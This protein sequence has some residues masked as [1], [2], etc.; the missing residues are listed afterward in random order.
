MWE[1]GSVAQLCSNSILIYGSDIF[2]N[3]FISSGI[4]LGEQEDEDPE[5]WTAKMLTRDH[6]PECEIELARIEASGGKV[7]GNSRGLYIFNNKYFYR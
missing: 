4:I 3:L 6:K 7:G 2:T 1:T 5:D